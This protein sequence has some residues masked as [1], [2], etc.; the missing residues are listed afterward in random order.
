MSH[1]SNTVG[2]LTIA[3]GQTRSNILEAN[4]TYGDSTAILVTARSGNPLLDY[5]WEV[6]YDYRLGLNKPASEQ[7]T[8]TATWYALE[9][10]SLAA[11]TLPAA[12]RARAY[13]DVVLAAAIRVRASA[14]VT[15]TPAIFDVI[16][17]PLLT[18]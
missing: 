10:D 18:E 8:S 3:V 16:K 2:Q 9:D 13:A 4:L 7:V 1:F 17:Q 6:S 11:V 15:G 5:T 12:G 14:T